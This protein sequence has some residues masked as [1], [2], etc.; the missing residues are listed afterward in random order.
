VRRRGAEG[1]SWGEGSQA[2][3]SCGTGCR[4]YLYYLLVASERIKL[5]LPKLMSGLQLVAQL[6]SCADTSVTQGGAKGAA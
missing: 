1:S 6:S 4:K 5:S 3:K 2:L